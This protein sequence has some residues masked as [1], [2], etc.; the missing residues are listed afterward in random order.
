MHGRERTT[1]AN[2]Q[3]LKAAGVLPPNVSMAA[4]LRGLNATVGPEQERYSEM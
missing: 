1:I 2:F 3:Y 4:L